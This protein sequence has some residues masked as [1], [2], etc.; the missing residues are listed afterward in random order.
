MSV[1]VDKA[2]IDVILDKEQNFD[3]TS[4]DWEPKLIFTPHKPTGF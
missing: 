2:G 3:S 4:P 1:K